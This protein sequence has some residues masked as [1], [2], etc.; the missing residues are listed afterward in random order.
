M[1]YL[2]TDGTKKIESHCQKLRHSNS[3]SFLSK[4]PD[5]TVGT[6]RTFTQLWCPTELSLFESNIDNGFH[7]SKTLEDAT[8]K[9]TVNLLKQQQK[10]VCNK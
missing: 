1:N 7:M 3:A 8:I 10:I 9:I 2:C 6:F 4:A 5:Q